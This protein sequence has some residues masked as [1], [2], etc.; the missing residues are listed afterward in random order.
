[1]ERVKKAI[2]RGNNNTAFPHSFCV[3]NREISD[4]TEIAGTF[5]EFFANIGNKVN[6]S[7]PPATHN[8]GYFMPDHNV[9]SMFIDPVV[10]AD[11]LNITSKLKPKTSSGPD[12]ISTKLLIK[13]I[14]KIVN[15]ITHII[16]LTF[17]TGVFPSAMKCA[18]VIPIY[19]SGD[20]SSLNNYRPISLLSPFSKIFE[21][22]MFSKIMK[23]LDQNDILY[24]H[25]YGFRAKHSTIH[26][27][28]HFLNQC[29]TACN[30]TPSQM[31]L[32]TFCDLSKAFDTISHDILLYKLNVYGIRGVANDW[33]NSYLTERTQYVEYNSHKSS[34][35]AIKCGVPQGS[36]LGPLL[37][38]IYINDI[39]NSTSENI[40][41]FADDTTVFLSDSNPVTL[42]QRANLSLSKIFNWFCANKLSLN[43]K[44]TQYMVLQPAGINRNL[45]EQ[46]LLINDITLSQARHCKFLGI[47][48]DD[49]L[50]WKH[51]LSCVNSK[52]SRALFAIKQ[53][54]FSLPKDS[55]RIL[56]F[57]LIHP[58]L[59][60]G[61]LAWGNS[62][63]SI[64]RKTEI[65]QK[66]ALRS[67]NLSRYNSHTDPLFKQ[68]GILKLRDLYQL[69]VM[70]FMHD[71]VNQKLPK[72]FVNTY[73]LNRDVQDVYL[74]RQNNM[75]KIPKTKSRFVDRL[76]LFQ[77]P[78]LWNKHINEID[79]S[80]HRNS[81]K[82]TFK[83]KCFNSYNAVV[84]CDNPRCRDCQSS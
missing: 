60:Y 76:P 21:K 52:I 44:K 22:V 80:L 73:C 77:F 66:R 6:H 56:Y 3:D 2:G 59:T 68:S 14:H 27:V 35:L 38:L 24:N 8:F 16:N 48:I 57:A 31:T 54:K 63:P 17:E 45:S 32:A 67:I 18:K 15:P 83:H 25:Q 30:T 55:L 81:L 41:S 13:T 78:Y 64:I 72:S 82:R 84:N 40:L 74:T 23:F 10:P 4:K 7:V 12:G 75:F 33:I 69:N 58:H 19:K 28:L 9:N 34:G 26:P 49:M 29:A 65:I 47:T 43:A 37:F 61:I 71:Y 36:I 79:V 50:T 5:N 53:L 51:H 62:Q 46:K 1:M 42:F 20:Q 11:I 39:H 70:I